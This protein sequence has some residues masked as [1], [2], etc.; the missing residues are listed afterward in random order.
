MSDVVFY[1]KIASDHL[2]V[3]RIDR[4]EASNAVNTAVMEGLACGLLRARADADVRAVLLTGGGDRTFVAGGDLKEFH[5]DLT[6]TE[7]VYRK[8]S[9]MRDVLAT[10][11]FFEK[12]VIAAVNGAA[13]GGGGELAAACHF[14]I[15]SVTATVGFVQVKLGISPG[16]G[17][18]ALL[19]QIVGLQ[20]AKRMI[21]TG[22]VLTAEQ[23]QQ[24]GF[25]DDVVPADEL[26]EAAYSF[27]RSITRNAPEAVQA[28]LKKMH[29][30]YPA[31][32]LAE[33]EAES[34][35]C[36]DLWMTEAH[37]QAV[38]AFLNR[39]TAR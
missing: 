15:A 30:S 20:A 9:Q 26:T 36:A 39:K 37:L 34:R 21:L 4:P 14:R 27:A 28:L 10:L 18:G 13:R 25:F 32:L 2:A 29:A 23:A 33:M 38:E 22:D 7:S 1:E 17:G 8:M 11:A 5:H 6:D 12:P 3:L 24:I 35:L 16:W 19:R 31:D